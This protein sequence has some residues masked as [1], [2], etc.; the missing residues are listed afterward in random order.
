MP[1]K[2]IWSTCDGSLYATYRTI[3]GYLCHTYSRDDGRTWTPPAFSDL[4]QW[5]LN[6]TSARVCAGVEAQQWQHLFSAHK[7][8]RR[9]YMDEWGK[10]KLH[11]CNPV[12]VSGGVERNGRIEWSEPEILL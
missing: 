9:A 1:K 10:G 12:W 7:S 6:Q 11:G 8:R 2:S 5:S 4:C 3:D